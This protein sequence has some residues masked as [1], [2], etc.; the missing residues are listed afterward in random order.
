MLTGNEEKRLFLA[1][2]PKSRPRRCCR[3]TV[4]TS[5]SVS[6]YSKAET[7]ICTQKTS[8]IDIYAHILALINTNSSNSREC[9]I[10]RGPKGIEFQ[11][12]YSI[13]HPA[14]SKLGLIILLILYLTSSKFKSS[15]ITFQARK[16]VHIFCTWYFIIRSPMNKHER[17]SPCH[18]CPQH[19]NIDESDSKSIHNT[20]NFKIY[21]YS[22]FLIPNAKMR[23]FSNKQQ[24]RDVLTAAAWDEH[25]C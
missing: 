8:C 9:W 20:G 24:R 5:S 11:T 3:S 25:S 2:V 18:P 15:L 14:A 21:K 19:F 6:S 10:G 23:N 16:E 17:P 12:L 7:D 1:T 22:S 13:L 4:R